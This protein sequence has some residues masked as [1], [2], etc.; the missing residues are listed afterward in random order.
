[1]PREL[2]LCNASSPFRRSRSSRIVVVRI[3]EA[4]PTV[5]RKSGSVL[6]EV[7]SFDL[8]RR[9]AEES[10]GVLD[11][12]PL[13]GFDP[14]AIPSDAPPTDVV[15]TPTPAHALSTDAGPTDGLPTESPGASDDYSGWAETPSPAW[16]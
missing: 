1:M 16:P 10:I 15:P 7:Q 11:L 5:R 8:F 6:P 13:P 9:I 4:K 12:P 14:S 3:H 2:P